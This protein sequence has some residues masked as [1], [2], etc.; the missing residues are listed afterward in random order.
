MPVLRPLV[1]AARAPPNAHDY[2][3]AQPC[4]ESVVKEQ[5]DEQI[6]DGLR[7]RRA[8]QEYAEDVEPRERFHQPV[9]FGTRQR[10]VYRQEGE[11]RRSRFHF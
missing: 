3:L 6:R 10:L 1:N 11:S 2:E 4:V 5:R 7:Q 9:V 8:V